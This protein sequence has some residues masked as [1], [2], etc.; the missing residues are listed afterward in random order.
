MAADL[1]LLVSEPQ[2]V[3]PG[4]DVVVLLPL[5]APGGRGGDLRPVDREEEVVDPVRQRV[6]FVLALLSVQF[7][8]RAG[9]RRRGRRRPAEPRHTERGERRCA[10]HRG[11]GEMVEVLG[12]LC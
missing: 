9:L 3:Q 4:H 12:L 6:E 7:Q 8:D 5:Q 11:G 2:S 10:R 1:V